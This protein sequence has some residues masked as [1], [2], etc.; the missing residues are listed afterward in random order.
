MGEGDAGAPRS[1][2]ASQGDAFTKRE[3]ADE[4]YAIRKREME[5]LQ[6]LKEKIA[7]HQEHL[8]ELDKN[9]YVGAFFF[10]YVWTESS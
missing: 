3:N 2:G 6:A 8:T 9:V 1:G 7:E 4:N 10:P 5:K